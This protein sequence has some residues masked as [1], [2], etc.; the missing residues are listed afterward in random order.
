MLEVTT[1]LRVVMSEPDSLAEFF[2]GEL[3]TGRT[4]FKAN[5]TLLRAL[6]AVKRA[7]VLFERRPNS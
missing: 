6:F 1:Y 3:P 7:E 5:G 4:L 2:R